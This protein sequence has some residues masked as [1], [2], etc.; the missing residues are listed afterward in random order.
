MFCDGLGEFVEGA[1][2]IVVVDVVGIEK[3]TGTGED[4][5]AVS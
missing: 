1:D 3:E 5:V 4:A 2:Y